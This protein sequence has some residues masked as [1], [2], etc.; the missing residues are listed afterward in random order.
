MTDILAGPYPVPPLPEPA[1]PG[2]EDP[3]AP[4]PVEEPPDAI[5]VPPQEPPPMPERLAGR[6]AC[7]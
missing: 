4:P 2:R 6:G 1:G 3:D 5:P 7:G